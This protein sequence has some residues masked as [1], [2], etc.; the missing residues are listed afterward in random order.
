ME[1]Y[2]TFIRI[3][4]SVQNSDRSKKQAEL[5]E[6]YGSDKK[7]KEIELLNQTQQAKDSELAKQ[8]VVNYS[9][10]G[11]LALVIIFSFFVLKANRDRKKANDLL[12]LQKSIIEEKNRHITDSI[13]YAQT[14]QSAI[15][16][17]KEEFSK[18]FSDSFVCYLPKDIV[19]GDFY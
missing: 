8:K 11:G 19:S 10:G 12:Y 3:R 18:H 14:I 15:I 7:D 16:P 13:N 1:E 2:K 6:K 4:D 9:I 5:E 17:D